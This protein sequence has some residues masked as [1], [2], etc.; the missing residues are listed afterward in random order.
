MT[1]ITVKK[2]AAS[3]CSAHDCEYVALAED[4]GATLATSDTQILREFP[5]LTVSLKAFPEAARPGDPID[6]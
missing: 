3:T 4:L 6:A 1:T 2:I 5:A